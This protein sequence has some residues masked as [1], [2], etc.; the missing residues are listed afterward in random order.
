MAITQIQKE[1]N[2][3]IPH[4]PSHPWSK[5]TS[6]SGNPVHTIRIGTRNAAEPTWIGDSA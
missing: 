6:T 5:S 4:K 3:R 2:T 1:H